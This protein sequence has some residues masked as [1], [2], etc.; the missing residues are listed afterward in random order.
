MLFFDLRSGGQTILAVFRLH[1]HEDQI[2]RLLAAEL[3]G[4]IRARDR[5]GQRKRRLFF[6]I[7]FQQLS[8]HRLIFHDQN[9]RHADS[10]CMG[11]SIVSAKRG[12]L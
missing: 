12:R 5:R 8:H 4:E 11:S 2:D 9:I 3:R 1:V 6:Y 10:S 7:G